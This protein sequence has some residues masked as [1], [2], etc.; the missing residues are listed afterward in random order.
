[1]ISKE[2]RVSLKMYKEQYPLIDY[3]IKKENEEG[4]PY[5]SFYDIESN[6]I[7]DMYRVTEDLCKDL[8][9]NKLFKV[10]DLMKEVEEWKKN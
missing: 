7:I 4:E 9:K 6:H 3:L 8:E 10:E 5:T 2:D 1:M